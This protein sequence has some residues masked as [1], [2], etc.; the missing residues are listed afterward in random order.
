[1]LNVTNDRK[2]PLN[3]VID[4]FHMALLFLSIRRWILEVHLKLV[5]Q[6]FVPPSYPLNLFYRGP[7]L[8]CDMLIHR[9]DLFKHSH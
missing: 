7:L 1:M 8:F 9:S 2:Y 3:S 6:N 5:M 4:N